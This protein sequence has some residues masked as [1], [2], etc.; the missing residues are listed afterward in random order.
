MVKRFLNHTSKT[1]LSAAFILAITTLLSRI[2]GLIR[3]RL[4]AGEFG[5]GNE[6]DI[7]F[8]AFSLPDLIYS[9]LIMGAISSA[10]IP[11]FAQYFKKDEEDA[12][13]LTGGLLSWVILILIALSLILIIFAPQVVSIIAPG[14]SAAKKAMTVTLTRIMFLSP[15][16][17]GISSIFSGVLQ[18][19]NRFLIY[20]LAPIMYNLGIIIGI[21]FLVPA[22]GLTGLAWGVVLGAFLHFLIQLPSAIYSGFKFK[23]FF[24]LHQG[25][26]K[27]ITLTIPRTIGLAA[28]QINYVVITAIASGL[29]VGS[30]A[31][32]NLS[33]NLQNVPIGIIGISF[34]MAVF[35]RLA[36]SSAE[37][38]KKSFF[39]NFS[40][41]FNQILYL[42]LPISAIFFILRAQI[43]RLVLGTG[44]F[45]WVDTRLTAAAL[46][47]FAISIFAQSL[48][49]LI[50]RAFYSLH[51]TKTPVLIS[52]ASIGLNILMSFGFVWILNQSNLFTEFFSGIFKLSGIK[53]FAV[54]GFPMAFSLSGIFNF[55]VLMKFFNRKTRGY[56]ARDIFSSVFKSVFKIVVS[57]ILMALVIYGLLQIFNLIFNTK[58][59]IGLF[60][61]TS[62]SGLIG[63]G[64][65]FIISLLFKLPESMAMAKKFLFKSKRDTLE[66]VQPSDLIK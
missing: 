55:A 20:S 3:D 17:L 9:I 43:I 58:T 42:I 44:Q 45:G 19:F 63:I 10:F 1:V 2:L 57:C 36:S 37:N 12:W 61:Q 52:L 14:F 5:A 64:V 30:I 40:L 18:Y 41:V 47:I 28:T 49:P 8:S 32:F 27:I 65:Y 23:G 59:F 39:T 48:I 7:Y 6:L 66:E 26:K 35:P 15:L 16:I 22:M 54:L 21:V 38:D 56:D 33:D 13:K 34:A 31:I 46:G 4:L 25:I 53:N 62:I 60:L 24:K 50:S 11:I 51:D 29:T